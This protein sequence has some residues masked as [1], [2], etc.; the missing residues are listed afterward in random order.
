[1]NRRAPHDT[2]IAPILVLLF[3]VAGLV[4]LIAPRVDSL[5]A[6]RGAGDSGTSPAAADDSTRRRV[7]LVSP[8]GG[9]SQD[10]PE[11]HRPIL[12]YLP[13][14]SR[15]G[16]LRALTTSL[17]LEADLQQQVHH[18]V[19]VLAHPPQDY[20]YPGPLPEETAVQ[21]IFLEGDLLLVDLASPFAAPRGK[22]PTAARLTLYSL[23]N[24]L[25]SLPSV[26]RVRILIDGQETEAYASTMRLD[27]P[28]EFRA[29]M[30]VSG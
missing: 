28:F 8:A 17:P 19:K 30:V 27:Q 16:A 11:G 14:P 23:V 4:F 24:T 26:E 5:W 6:P 10:I 22:G 12:V 18:A 29:D 21:A 25:T 3:V 20:P 13:D 15:P 9:G 7:P 2:S 1:M